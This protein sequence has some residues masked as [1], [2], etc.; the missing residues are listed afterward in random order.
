MLECDLRLYQ[1]SHSHS[2][3]EYLSLLRHRQQLQKV[4]SQIVLLHTF[5]LHI[6]YDNVCTLSWRPKSLHSE[7]RYWEMKC[8]YILLVFKKN[9]D[10]SEYRVRLKFSTRFTL[11]KNWSYI[12]APTFFFFLCVCLCMCVCVCFSAVLSRLSALQSV[13]RLF[14]R[15]SQSWKDSNNWVYKTLI[16]LCSSWF[17][18]LSLL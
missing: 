12:P 18:S 15:L 7:I 1:Q 17:L 6:M 4:S 2:D 3:E 5:R 9:T 13:K 11:T 16:L 14:F 10:A 8:V